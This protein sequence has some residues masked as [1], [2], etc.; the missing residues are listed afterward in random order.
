M[1][2]DLD[3]KYRSGTQTDR[4]CGIALKGQF[5][6]LGGNTNTRQVT[7]IMKKVLETNIF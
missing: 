2:D 6:Y 3:F 5:W 7:I 1:N 4:G